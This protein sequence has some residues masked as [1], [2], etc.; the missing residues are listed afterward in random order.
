MASHRMTLPI[1]ATAVVALGLGG[2]QRWLAEP[3]TAAAR[4]SGLTLSAQL[5]EGEDPAADLRTLMDSMNVVLEAEGANY[6]VAIAEY[7]TDEAGFNGQDTVLAKNVGNKRLGADFIPGDPR[8]NGWSGV[9]PDGAVDNITYAIDR[10]GDAVPVF[11]LVGGLTAAQTDAA[12]VRAVTTWENVECSTVGLTR[13]NDFGLDIGVVA[14]QNSLGGSPFIFA[15]VQ[16]AGWR[17]INFAGGILGVTFTFVFINA[18]GPTD[19]DGNGLAD[20][21]FREIYFDPSFNWRDDGVGNV[22]VQTV[23][24]HEFG[25]GLSQG[26]FGMIALKNDGSLKAS[27]RAVMNALYAGPFR[28]LVGTD[29]GGHCGNWETWPTN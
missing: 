8:R 26:H 15:D 6:R 17:D 16:H 20:V 21:A 23:A 10:T 29:N 14:F 3:E 28:V 12:I 27:P 18:A 13:N 2:C 5:T 11:P 1:A 22:D 7:I 24:L 19:N 25:H 9:T 4:G